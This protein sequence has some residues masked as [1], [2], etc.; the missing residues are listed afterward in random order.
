LENSPLFN[1]G[2]GAVFTHDK[3]NEMDASIMTGHD[4][5]AGAVAGVKNIKNPISAARKVMTVSEHVLLSGNGASDFA[6]EQ[7]LE[8]VPQAI[9][10]PKK[11]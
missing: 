6:K 8:I 5:N 1:A 4:L 3:T 10:I 9:F 7:G 11:A 2:K